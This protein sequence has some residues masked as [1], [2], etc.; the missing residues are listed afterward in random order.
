MSR[1]FTAQRGRFIT[2]GAVAL[3]IFSALFAAACGDDDSGDPTNTPAPSTPT[4]TEPA[5]ETPSPAPEEPT[6]T[7]TPEVEDPQG[8]EDALDEFE[9]ELQS[10]G[11]DA[12]VARLLVQEYTCKASDLEPGIGRPDCTVA[13]EVIRA[14]QMS[15]WR[16]EGGL[17]KIESVVAFLQQVDADLATGQS[18]EWGAGQ[19]DIYAFDSTIDRAVLTMMVKC[20][21]NHQCTDGYQR[22]AMVFDFTF[23]DDRWMIDRLMNAFVLFEDFLEPTAE[24]GAYFPEWEKHD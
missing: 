6:I 3:L 7:P 9:D 8:F 10:G 12:I 14:F 20:Q 15:G 19:P 17:R 2:L 24:G 22:V 5:G 13:G 4:P 1:A 11:L 23:E 18:D 16:S 21:P